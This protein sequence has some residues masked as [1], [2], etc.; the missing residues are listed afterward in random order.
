MSRRV[1]VVDPGQRVCA[2]DLVGQREQRS[3]AACRHRLGDRLRR[4]RDPIAVGVLSLHV[5]DVGIRE[6][7]SHH[8]DRGGRHRSEDPR[9]EAR[10]RAGRRVATSE[11]QLLALLINTVTAGPGLTRKAFRDRVPRDAGVLLLE[12]TPDAGGRGRSELLQVVVE[13]VLVRTQ[14]WCGSREGWGRELG[15][16][17]R[18]QD[19]RV[20]PARQRRRARPCVLEQHCGEVG[21][22]NPHRTG[23]WLLDDALGGVRDIGVV[24][25]AEHLDLR[26]TVGNRALQHEGHRADLH[27]RVDQPRRTALYLGQLRRC[28]RDSGEHEIEVAGQEVLPT[29]QGSVRR[30]AQVARRSRARHV[31]LPRQ[32]LLVSTPGTLAL[33]RDG[34]NLRCRRA[35]ARRRRDDRQATDEHSCELSPRRSE[36]TP[37]HAS[38]LRRMLLMTSD[39][40]AARPAPAKTIQIAFEA[41]LVG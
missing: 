29:E 36:A 1:Q 10:D 12:P 11:G 31:V 13:L 21:V 6:R 22:R 16:V 17:H 34:G 25:I 38:D 19:T 30:I 23:V 9:G 18:L 14:H 15:H 32:D 7:L 37:G 3:V 26:E 8:R 5:L 40:A 20:V 33:E 39:A 28:E 41:C 35:V 27:R 2:G 4:R 24:R